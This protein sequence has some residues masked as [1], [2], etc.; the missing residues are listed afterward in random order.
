MRK[1]WVVMVSLLALGGCATEPDATANAIAQSDGACSAAAA[2]RTRDAAINGYDEAAQHGIWQDA[3]NSCV[4]WSK[5]SV[6]V[7][8]GRH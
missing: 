5:K 4:A 2:A 6:L 1:S 7:E 3:Y 8:A